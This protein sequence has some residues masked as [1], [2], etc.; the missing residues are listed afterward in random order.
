MLTTPSIIRRPLAP[1]CAA[2]LLFA[3]CANVPTL[4]MA[5]DPQDGM[6]PPGFTPRRRAGEGQWG[7]RILVEGQYLPA[8]WLEFDDDTSSAP[9]AV[10]GS[11][12]GDGYGGR[13]A[14][15]NKDQSIGAM[16]QGFDL[17]GD[18]GTIR[19]DS[20]YVD[21]DVRVPLSEGGGNFSL[22]IGAGLGGAR[23]DY[24]NG[25]GGVDNEG[26]AQLRAVL[27]FNPSRAFSFDVGFGGVIYGHPGE[28]EAYGS[29][30][31]VGMTTAF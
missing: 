17:S 18:I 29:Y 10:D 4:P 8:A 30:V 5:Q 22:L 14:I 13:F 11:A 31:L 3:A 23:F 28:T 9:S 27:N 21:F 20:L 15:G 12:D 25:A 24:D 26:A 16:Y 19:I 6:Q 2:S 7:E 1:L